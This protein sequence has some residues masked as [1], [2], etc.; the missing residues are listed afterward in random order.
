MYDTSLMVNIMSEIRDHILVFAM[1]RSIKLIPLKR[2]EGPATI[3]FYQEPK[4]KCFR[5]RLE[6]DR[7]DIKCDTSIHF[8]LSCG[9][10][11]IQSGHK[12]YFFK[13]VYSIMY[14]DQW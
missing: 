4:A 12:F 3:S 6:C 7:R 1:S 5:R 9:D 13:H 8:S 2:V 11:L 10:V 14:M